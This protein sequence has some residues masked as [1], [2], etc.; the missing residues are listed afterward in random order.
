MRH[1][2][3]IVH[4]LDQR[5]LIDSESYEQL[6]WT[7]RSRA[8]ATG[9]YVVSWPDHVLRARFDECARYQG[10]FRTAAHARIALQRH[11]G[12]PYLESA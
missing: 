8:L 6:Y 9:Y 12:L 4:V 5:R 7:T 11:L 2:P 1:D 3:Q 10:P